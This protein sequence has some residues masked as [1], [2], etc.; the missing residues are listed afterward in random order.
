[1][2]PV[3]SRGSLR[4]Q[5]YLAVETE[6]MRLQKEVYAMTQRLEDEEQSLVL[7]EGEIKE[8]DEELAERESSVEKMK[9]NQLAE[10]NSII[11]MR[12]TS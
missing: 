6:Q 3:E 5:G 12:S 10:N 2:S 7:I 11:K 4:F 8:A 1:M 9:P